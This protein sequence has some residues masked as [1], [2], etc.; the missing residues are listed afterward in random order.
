MKTTNTV[1]VLVLA[2]LI[3]F[4]FGYTTK[5]RTD[6][7]FLEGAVDLLNQ[8]ADD[9]ESLQQARAVCSSGAAMQWWTRA[10]NL[11]D[12]RERLCGSKG[13]KGK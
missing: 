2:G 3:G 10:E 13:N 7:E 11:T 8:A 4:G 5:A 6:A 12:V 1:A 9:A